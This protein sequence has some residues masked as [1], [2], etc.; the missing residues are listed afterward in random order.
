MRWTFKLYDASGD[1]ALE[2]QEVAGD[3]VLGDLDDC[4]GD[5][6]DGRGGFDGG[7]GDL[8]DSL[9][10]L[11]DGLKYNNYFPGSADNAIHTGGIL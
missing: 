10:D 4:L 6:E 11:E 1:G 3:D 7:L 9:G 5:L 8:D 2:Q